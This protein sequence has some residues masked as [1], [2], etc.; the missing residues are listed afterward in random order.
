MTR[1]KIDLLMDMEES[2][3]LGRTYLDQANFVNNLGNV[4]LAEYYVNKAM[5]QAEKYVRIRNR[6]R[7]EFHTFVM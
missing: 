5:E 2:E 7:N 3:R 1:T 6:L 4:D